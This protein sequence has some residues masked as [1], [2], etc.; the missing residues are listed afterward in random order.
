WQAGANWF[1]TEGDTWQVNMTGE[2]TTKVAEFWQ[3]MIEDGTVRYQQ[4]FSEDW[5][6]DLDSGNVVGVIGAVWGVAGLVSRTESSAGD[7]RV[8]ELPSWDG[9]PA[10]AI[11]GGSTFV[12]TDSSEHAEAAAEFA[13]WLATSPEG[14]EA[15]GDFGVAYPA[16]PD[17]LKVARDSVD[18]SHFGGQEIYDVFDAAYE[19]IVPGWMWGPVQ[20]TWQSLSDE[21][22]NVPDSSTISDALQASQ[23][24]T[25]AEMNELGLSVQTP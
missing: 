5:A 13:T 19:S 4:A 2:A 23:D 10:S 12:V 8:A 7:W 21:L 22:G 1:G 9:K 20:G 14:L 16:N 17:L 24:A 15:R 6:N 18:T 3:G 25:V 11:Y